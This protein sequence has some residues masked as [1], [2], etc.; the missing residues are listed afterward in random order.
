MYCEDLGEICPRKAFSEYLCA[1]CDPMRDRF[2]NGPS[3]LDVMVLYSVNIPV[4]K[5]IVNKNKIGTKN[6][7]FGYECL[8]C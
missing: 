3:D 8:F 4:H 6:Y 5:H 1:I 2:G 7:V